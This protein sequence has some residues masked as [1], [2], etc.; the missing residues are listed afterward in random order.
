MDPRGL[1]IRMIIKVT[2]GSELGIRLLFIMALREDH[3]LKF[4]KQSGCLLVP[5]RYQLC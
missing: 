5:R 3:F 2:T 1:A 4:T